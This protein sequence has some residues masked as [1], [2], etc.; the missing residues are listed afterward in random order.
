VLQSLD[1]TRKVPERETITLLCYTPRPALERVWTNSLDV[2]FFF[3]LQS[4]ID[5]NL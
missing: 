2:E 1:C 5:I 4:K 3:D